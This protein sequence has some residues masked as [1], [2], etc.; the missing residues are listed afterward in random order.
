MDSLLEGRRAKG[1]GLLVAGASRQTEVKLASVTLSAECLRHAALEACF[2]LETGDLQRNLLHL[3]SEAHLCNKGDSISILGHMPPPAR[4]LYTPFC[5]T[6]HTI[7]TN[8]RNNSN[9]CSA[10]SSAYTC[11]P[12]RHPTAYCAMAVFRLL[13]CNKGRRRL[14]RPPVS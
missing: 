2:L 3:W 12:R 1:R 8:K 6:M 9:T 7:A 4:R 10:S 11:K 5:G 14:A 13:L